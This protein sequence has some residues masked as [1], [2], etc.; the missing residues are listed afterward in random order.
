MML[1]LPERPPVGSHALG[2]AAG[3]SVPTT[4]TRASNKIVRRR[5]RSSESPLHT[6]GRQGRTQ[7]TCW[8]RSLA[9]RRCRCGSGCGSAA[10]HQRLCGAISVQQR[11][12]RQYRWR[13]IDAGFEVEVFVELIGLLS[14]HGDVDLD[15]GDVKVAAVR[16][17][18]A[19]WSG[20]LEPGDE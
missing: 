6:S 19:E 17:F 2:G 14:R 11:A 5:P 9:S 20:E 1:R 10:T 18:F 12:D 7:Q 16:A 13:E 8:P 15:L 4:N 3:A